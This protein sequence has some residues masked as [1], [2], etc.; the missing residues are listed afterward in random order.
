MDMKPGDASFRTNPRTVVVLGYGA[1]GQ[2]LVPLLFR[3]FAASRPRLVVVA[4]D[5]PDSLGD[6][7]EEVEFIRLSLTQDNVAA[8]LG[9]VLGSGDVLIN[10][11]VEVASHDLVVWCRAHRVSY[12]DTCV[13]PWAGGYGAMGVSSAQTNYFLRHQVLSL[14]EPGATTAVIAHGA[15]P[16][17]VTHFTK[18]ALLE[19]AAIKGISQ[20][21][22]WAELASLLE[23]R[24]VQIAERDTQCC[25]I[26]V[27]PQ[28][29]FNT[30]SVDGLMAEAWQYG[31]L[32][33]GS[34]E[35]VFPSSGVRHAYGDGAAIYLKENSASI[36]VR[37]WVPSVGPQ[38]GYL[39]THHEA[40]SIASLL[41]L[42]GETA[43]RP[44]YRPTVY[45]AYHPTEM[46]CHSLDHWV[47]SGF[48]A[49]RVKRVLKDE[50]TSGFDQLGV[51]LIFPGGAYWYGSTLELPQARS[52]A[53][54]NNATTLQVVAGILGGVE[55]MLRHPQAGVVEAE[56]MDFREV[57][58]VARP[59]LGH[60]SGIFTEW[61]PSVSGGLQ[62]SDFRLS[63]TPLS[64]HR[65]KVA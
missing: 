42:P 9:M 3:H 30:W 33:W 31:E 14:H 23:V 57:L 7:P 19:L 22:S 28:D 10:V 4:P 56:S 32:G 49:P 60:V 29:F 63:C 13:E 1:I 55:W 39:I 48:G 27:R 44:R 20:W 43:S 61:Q 59:Y 37:S 45:Y 62:F 21:A 26:P 34:H 65:E 53:P 47:E 38:W 8:S 18:A 5:I 64:M 54:H 24:V 35:R 11:S 52:L 58:E 25:R 16:G 15:N 6:R 40:I 46:T 51:L 41:T 50:L 17:L 12:L 36:R 2:A